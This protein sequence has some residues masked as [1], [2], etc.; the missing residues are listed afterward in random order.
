M[1]SA[2]ERLSQSTS[3]FLETNILGPFKKGTVAD[4]NALK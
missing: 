3:K 4:Q 2:K 1:Q